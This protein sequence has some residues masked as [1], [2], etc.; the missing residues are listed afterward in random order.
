MNLQEVVLPSP[1][2]QLPHSLDEWPTLNV[3]HRAAKLN[4][5]NIWLFI[6]IIH[7]YPCNSFYPILYRICKVG[8]NLHCFPKIV[9]STLSLYHVLVDLA[10]GYVVLTCEGDVEIAF[11][12]MNQRFGSVERV[13]DSFTNSQD[14]NLPRP[15]HQVQKPPH[16]LA[17]LALN[18]LQILSRQGAYSVAVIMRQLRFFLLFFCL[19]YSRA[20]VP[21]STF[22]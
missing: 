11:A 5:A 8:H 10:C 13:E 20:I 17:K 14:P 6:G 19:E 9:A 22:I 2:S 1:P 3:S 18:N 7:G 21:A 16:A 12:G 15:H 4:Y